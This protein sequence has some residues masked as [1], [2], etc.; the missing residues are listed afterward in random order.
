[1][2]MKV[3]R[4]KTGR[5]SMRRTRRG[6]R[7]RKGPKEMG[8]LGVNSPGKRKD[9]EPAGSVG[10]GRWY[11]RT[12]GEG[13]AGSPRITKTSKRGSSRVTWKRRS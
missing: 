9:L 3:S 4:R 10:D 7:Q 11:G 5:S 8:T 1:M 2:R 12:R 13:F 6:R